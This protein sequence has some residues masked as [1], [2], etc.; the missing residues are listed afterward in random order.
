MPAAEIV[1]PLVTLYSIMLGGFGFIIKRYDIDSGCLKGI[2]YLAGIL[3]SLT[4]LPILLFMYTTLEASGQDVRSFDQIEIFGAAILLMMFSL[5][6]LIVLF[7]F[8]EN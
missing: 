3:L 5:W 1:G 4:V 7:I 2:K 8:T 6:F